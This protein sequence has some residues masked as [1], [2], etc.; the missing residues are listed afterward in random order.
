MSDAADDIVSA[1]RI[2]RHDGS[3]WPS[4]M[5]RI[6][7]GNNKS[8]TQIMD[9]KSCFLIRSQP[10]KT[11][12]RQHDVYWRVDF[13]C[14]WAGELPGVGTKGKPGGAPAAST[15]AT[16]SPAGRGERESE[17]IGAHPSRRAALVMGGSRR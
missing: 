11:N 1:S 17:R 15:S 3:L 7:F 10:D 16:A 12:V 13:A 4:H 8:V 5:A 14:K 6:E 9:K 2:T